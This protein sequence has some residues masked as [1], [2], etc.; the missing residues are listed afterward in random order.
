MRETDVIGRW[1]GE[2]F[3]ILMRDTDPHT[4]G[5]RALSRLRTSL[6]ELRLP[7][8][9]SGLKITFSAGLADASS[10]ELLQHTLERADRALYRAKAAGRN[11]DQIGVQKE[12][13]HHSLA[14]T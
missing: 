10:N 11:C 4:Q 7:V 13:V 3:L 5:L 1:G 14:S 9:N 2:E 6:A 8:Q 12:V